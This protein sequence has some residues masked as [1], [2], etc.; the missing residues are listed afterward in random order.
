MNISS[1][2]ALSSRLQALY[3]PAKHSMASQAS[4]FRSVI[5]SQL[6]SK[7]PRCVPPAAR[8]W[9]KRTSAPG[10]RGRTPFHHSRDAEKPSKGART[11]HRCVSNVHQLAVKVLGRLVAHNRP[12]AA[13]PG[14]LSRRA[15][16]CCEPALVTALASASF[17]H[18]WPPILHR[19]TRPHTSGADPLHARPRAASQARE[20]WWG[21]AAFSVRTAHSRAPLPSL[22]SGA[23]ER[24]RSGEQPGEARQPA[25]RR[26]EG[27]TAADERLPGVRATAAL[28]S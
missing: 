7:A 15:P 26:A 4:Q 24:W 22:R 28:A 1:Q 18:A 27:R 5:N 25:A 14:S 19:C 8:Q 12:A 17:H 10:A 13:V 23:S 3:Y 9:N 21:R 2:I 11:P 20:R 16:H 6:R